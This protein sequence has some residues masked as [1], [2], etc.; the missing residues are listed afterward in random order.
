MA[1]RPVMKQND[2]VKNFNILE[3]DPALNVVN[4]EKNMF[5]VSLSIKIP[6]KNV[7]IANG[8]ACKKKNT[9]ITNI[10]EGSVMYGS[11]PIAPRA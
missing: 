2:S 7:A 5:S 10:T 11:L 4:D 8:R 9:V 6:D 1:E 3:S